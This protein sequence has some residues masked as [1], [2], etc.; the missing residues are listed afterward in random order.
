MAG[1]AV[2]GQPAVLA[3]GVVVLIA[4]FGHLSQYRREI[5]A[6]CGQSVLR[7]RGYF[8]VTFLDDDAVGGQIFEALAEG[9]RINVTDRFFEFTETFRAAG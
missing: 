3:A 8:G 6:L 2:G 1:S 5:V 7:T 9:A 4:P